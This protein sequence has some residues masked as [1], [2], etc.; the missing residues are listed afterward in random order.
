MLTIDFKFADI[1]VES[2]EACL[3]KLKNKLS[4]DL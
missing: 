4:E 1:K 3:L 2:S